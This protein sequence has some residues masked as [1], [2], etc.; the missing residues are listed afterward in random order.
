MVQNKLFIIILRHFYHVITSRDIKYYYNTWHWRHYSR[1]LFCLWKTDHLRWA[2]KFDKPGKCS[3]EILNCGPNRSADPVRSWTISQSRA[4]P[5]FQT[6]IGTEIGPWYHRT[7]RTGLNYFEHQK[8]NHGLW[9]LILDHKLCRTGS[10]LRTILDHTG[11]Y[12]TTDQ[13]GPLRTFS[14]LSS[15]R[16]GWKWHFI[17]VWT[18]NC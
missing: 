11:P 7:V 6:S 5:K 9:F 8:L 4:G 12:W 16:C 17:T 10:G 14:F 3:Q 18:Y 15:V 13:F 1:V 2:R